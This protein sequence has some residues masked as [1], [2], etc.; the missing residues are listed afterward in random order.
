MAS[1]VEVRRR[2]PISTDHGGEAGPHEKRN[3]GGGT[4]R[5]IRCKVLKSLAI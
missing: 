4:K 2:F 1:S 3:M 5:E